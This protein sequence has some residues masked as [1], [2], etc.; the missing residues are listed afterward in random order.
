MRSARA[1]ARWPRATQVVCVTHL[2]QIA[3]WADRTFALRK[4]EARGDTRSKSSTLD[5]D[6]VTAEIARMLSGGA[7]G[8]ALEHADA[9]L[10]VVRSVRRTLR[11][12]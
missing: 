5:G 11:S 9:L 1:S 4:H 6:D 12:A 10:H 8:V 7:T 2:A 3:S